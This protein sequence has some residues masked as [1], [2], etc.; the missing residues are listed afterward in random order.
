M[1]SGRASQPQVNT[2]TILSLVCNIFWNCTR[3]L[4]KVHH[5][6]SMASGILVINGASSGSTRSKSVWHM[7]LTFVICDGP[8]IRC[9]DLGTWCLF[10]TTKYLVIT[11][12]V[13]FIFTTSYL[14]L[15]D[16]YIY[17]YVCVCVK[18]FRLYNI[19]IYK[20]SEECKTK[21][22]SIYLLKFTWYTCPSLFWGDNDN[23]F[24]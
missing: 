15:L 7:L 8:L 14:K 18:Q 3:I 2:D 6:G 5:L 10:R 12:F 9:F 24:G 16:I 4:A 13:G 19:Y 1:F 22:K 20:P 23:S 11:M 17:I 21:Q